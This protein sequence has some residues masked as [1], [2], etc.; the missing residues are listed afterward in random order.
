[1]IKKLFTVVVLLCTTTITLTAQDYNPDWYKKKANYF[2]A[3]SK[4]TDNNFTMTVMGTIDEERCDS[5]YEIGVFCGD[6]CRLSLPFYSNANY[7]SKYFYFY[8]PY[9]KIFHCFVT[10]T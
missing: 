3:V 10:V 1:M 9:G 7:F 4:T 6:E 5:A 8:F 2:K